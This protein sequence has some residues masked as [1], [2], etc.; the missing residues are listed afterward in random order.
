MLAVVR[1]PFVENGDQLLFIFYVLARV[2]G[3][4]LISPVLSNR[5]VTS[6]TKAMLVFLTTALIALAIYPDYF[7]ELARHSL[8]FLPPD[9]GFS[10]FLL[11]LHIGKEM[12]V[13]FL[14]GFCFFL[15]FE[16]LLLAGQLVGVMVGLSM[17]EI[18]DPVSGTNQSIVSQFFTVTISLILLTLDLHHHFFRV[19]GESYAFVPIGLY[20]MTPELM[21]DLAEGS[22]R[23]Y[24]YALQYAAI[25]YLVLF[26]V[27]FAL[28]FMARVM[29]E[30]N[31][32][33]V[34]FPLKIFIGYYSLI[35]ALAYFPLIFRKEFIEY[36]NLAHRMLT[37]MA[38]N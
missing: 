15:M 7:G 31:I 21:G 11:I 9:K 10:L 37:H 1:L 19:I 32:F 5:N 35:A 27:T 33:M 12:I 36:L 20:K 2:T 6:P 4:F 17:A 30:M 38:P 23:L 34:G 8:P 3:L 16:A 22:S 28:G 14:V 29:P 26:L 13:G 25:P 24:H 18:I